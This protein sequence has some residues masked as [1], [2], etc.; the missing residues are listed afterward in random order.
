ML[1][2][3]KQ[4]MFIKSCALGEKSLVKSTPGEN[5]FYDGTYDQNVDFHADSQ[6]RAR[7]GGS[8]LGGGSISA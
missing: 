5:G 3:L 8:V 1:V 4:K 7:P 6:T 2:K